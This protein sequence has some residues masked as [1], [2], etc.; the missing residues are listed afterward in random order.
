MPRAPA[1]HV[2]PLYG[3]GGS[4]PVLFVQKDQL[5]QGPN[6]RVL[7]HLLQLEEGRKKRGKRSENRQDGCISNFS[8]CPT[9]THTHLSHRRFLLP[10]AHDEDTV[11]LAD[12]ALSPWGHAVVGLIQNNPVDVLLLG[13]PAGQTIL[14][15]T[16]GTDEEHGDE[17]VEW[18]QSDS[19]YDTGDHGH[20][21][22]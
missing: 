20:Q 19:G 16:G 7:Q 13:Q 1:P 22:E 8:C 14:V 21:W 6:C 18:R 2:E 17:A 3:P 10:Q 12:A 4:R 11:S 9:H 5:L 15:D